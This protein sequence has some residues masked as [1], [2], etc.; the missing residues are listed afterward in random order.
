MLLQADQLQTST[1][2]PML[3]RE[4]IDIFF[5]SLKHSNMLCYGLEWGL[6]VWT[7]LCNCVNM[8]F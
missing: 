5:Q 7:C 1:Q 6:A 4:Q 2:L 8:V 3:G